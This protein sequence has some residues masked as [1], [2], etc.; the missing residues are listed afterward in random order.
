VQRFFATAP[1]AV[2]DTAPS[3]HSDR[4]LRR[5]FAIPAVAIRRSGIFSSTNCERRH[6]SDPI[7][8]FLVTPRGQFSMARDIALEVAPWP[9]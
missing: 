3:T 5:A 7:A 2:Q 4:R 9:G 8:C 1:R 6:L